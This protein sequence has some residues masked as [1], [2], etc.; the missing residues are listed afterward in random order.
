MYRRVILILLALAAFALPVTADKPERVESILF[1]TTWD[2]DGEGVDADQVVVAVAIEDSKIDYVIAA[3]PD[4]CRLL[5]LTIVDTNLNSGTLTVIGTDCWDDSLE[6]TFAFTA[7]D[8]TGIKTLTVSVG[9]ASG[10]YFKTV[11]A[12]TSGV[13]V[14]ESDETVAVGYGAT[15]AGIPFQYPMYGVR[16]QAFRTNVGTNYGRYI[17]VLDSYA[18]NLEV[19]TSGVASTTLTGVATNNPF[20][21][22]SVGDLLF[23]KMEGE[24]M[25]RKITARASAN[26]VT[27]DAAVNISSDGATFRWK[28]FYVFTDPFDGWFSV[29]GWDAIFGLWDV[30]SNT[31]TGGV[32]SD[33]RCAV[34]G[35]SYN[36]AQQIDTATVAST[37]TGSDAT[38]IDLRLAPVYTHCRYGVRFGTNDDDDTGVES[39]FISIGYRK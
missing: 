1:A 28:K 9:Q 27:L 5:D 31:D 21:N 3:D 35:T 26:S 32:I 12:L 2:M 10:A 22:I 30:V 29:Q 25:P 18:S 23:L 13:M 33:F 7:G 24:V 6:A 14:G 39:M 11:T 36:P 19:T 4:V 38:A 20:T 37:A 15:A 34:R 8:D 16:K 17:D